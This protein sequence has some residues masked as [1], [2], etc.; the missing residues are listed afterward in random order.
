MT[1]Y[2]QLIS[3]SDEQ[4][5]ANEPTEFNMFLLSDSEA[6]CFTD[7]KL[8]DNFL[9][10]LV[11]LVAR[12][13]KPLTTHIQ[14]IY[15]CYQTNLQEQLLAALV[16]LLVVLNSRGKAISW[17]M[18]IGTKSKLSGEHYKM[19][20]RFMSEDFNVALLAGNQYSVFTKDLIGTGNLVQQIET[21]AK[22]K[23]GPLAL[24]HDYIEYSQLAE[25]KDIL[26]KAIINQ[27][28]RLK[29]HQCLLELYKSTLDTS[30]FIKMF[31]IVAGLDVVMP[32]DWHTLQAFFNE[33][34][35]EKINAKAL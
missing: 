8:P 21:P 13:P 30:S 3:C 35:N 10:N 20:Q 27:P 34:N 12:K 25:A 18:I 2:S 19:L 17:R 33:R 6:F 11:L 16:D 7:K 1:L 31:N 23:H 28:H 26:E 9:K 14:R 24:A 22:Q 15:H 4:N 29:L 5:K 32:N